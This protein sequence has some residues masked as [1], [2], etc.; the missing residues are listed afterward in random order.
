MIPKLSSSCG[1]CCFRTCGEVTPEQPM[2]WTVR[3]GFRPKR[4]SLLMIW[5]YPPLWA[6]HICS[7]SY[8]KPCTEQISNSCPRLA[9]DWSYGSELKALILKRKSYMHDFSRWHVTIL[10][11]FIRMWQAPQLGST[12]LKLVHNGVECSDSRTI[13]LS[14]ISW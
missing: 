13:K 11:G 14:Y 3:F 5:G 2:N 4:S 12:H 1:T 10:L 8:S 6:A 7:R 9:Q